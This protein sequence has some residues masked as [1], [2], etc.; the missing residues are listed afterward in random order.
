MKKSAEE[1]IEIIAKVLALII[2]IL[3]IIILIEYAVPAKAGT[4][5]GEQHLGGMSVWLDKYIEEYGHSPYTEDI[6]LLAEVMFHENYTN[7]EEVM[8]YTGAV[9]MNRVF[10]P[11]Y[12]NSIKEVL[13]QSNQ[14]ST[15]SKFY[16]K[17]IPNDVYKLALK[18]IKLGTPDVPKTVLFQAMFR[19]GKVWKVIPSS[20]SSKDVEYFCYGR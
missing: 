4:V 5:T 17:E 1:R 8:Y 16:T 20:Y 10:S 6:E 9:V 11:N 19:Q 12:P 2:L 3:L 15:T 18:I 14:Y 13:Y 7:G